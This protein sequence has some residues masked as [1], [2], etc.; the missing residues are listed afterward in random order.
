MVRKSGKK[1]AGTRRRSGKGMQ[2][3]GG[4]IGPLLGS[5]ASSLF[6]SLFNRGKGRMYRRRI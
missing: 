2:R 4:F 1:S 3:H 5:L 6:G